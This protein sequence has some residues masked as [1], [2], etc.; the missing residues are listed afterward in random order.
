M[1]SVKSRINSL[2]SQAWHALERVVEQLEREWE[3][4]RRPTIDDLL[5]AE[6]TLRSALVIELAHAELECRLRA[7][8]PARAEDYLHKYPELGDD[9]AAALELIHTEYRIRSEHDPGLPVEEYLARFPHYS[10]EL[11]SRLREQAEPVPTTSPG[12]QTALDPERT[13]SYTPGP[14]AP[15]PSD[16]PRVCLRRP[17]D[18]TDLPLQDFTAALPAQ[19]G[20]CTILGVLARGGMG[21]VLK[22]HDAEL[23]RDLA[24][25]V[26]LD[27]FQDQPDL[28]RRFL[29][30]AQ[31]SG[32][33]QHPGIVPVY[34][35]GRLLDHR[36]YFT[37]KLVGGRTLAALL[38]ARAA[39]RHTANVPAGAEG[40]SAPQELPRFLK[41]FEQVCQTLAYAHARGVIHR[42]LKPAN[43]MVGAFGEVQVMDWGLAKVLV[44]PAS[45]VC[46]PTE[47]FPDHPTADL[48]SRAGS[49]AG[50]PA[51]MA[52][53]QAR[54][55]TERLDERCDVFGLGAI[56]CEMLTG[57]PPYVSRSA[58]DVMRQAEQGDLTHAFSRL[59][60]CAADGELLRLARSCLAV[61]VEDRPRDAGVVAG[62]MTAYLAGVQERL[63]AAEVAR[64]AAQAKAEEAK[65]KAAAERRAK[66][67][68][69]ALLVLA[70][71]AAGGLGTAAQLLYAAN[72]R[73]SEA[74]AKAEDH[75]QL[76]RQAR[77]KAED[78]LQ[79]ARS[80][81]NTYFTKV[82]DS[83]ELKAHGLEKL[84]FELLSAAKDFSERFAQEQAGDA[85]IEEE[86]AAAH[87]RLGLIA[88]E[89]GA[90]DQ[91]LEHRQQAVALFD[92]LAQAHPDDL[93]IQHNRATALLN[94]G[95]AYLETHQTKQA[96]AALE[97]SL[98]VR[99]QL[100]A[101]RPDDLLFLEALAQVNVNLGFLF[102]RTGE[103]ERARTGFQLA[104]T[105][106]EP[107]A[108]KYPQEPRLRYQ[109]AGSSY[110]LGQLQREAK[111]LSA[112]EADFERARVILTDLTLE[113][114]DPSYRRRLADTLSELAAIYTTQRKSKEANRFLALAL[115]L[116]ELLTMQ[117]PDVPEYKAALASNLNDLG[118]LY[119]TAAQAEKALQAYQRAFALFEELAQQE[120]TI[121]Y[122]REKMATVIGNV[123]RMNLRVGHAAKAQRACEQ[124][125]SISEKLANE[126]PL[127]V[128][129]QQLLGHALSNQAEFYAQTAQRILAQRTYE[130]AL[131]LY[132][133]L[134]KSHPE[135]PTYQ[136]GRARNLNDLAVL[137]RQAG[138]PGLAQERF[139]QAEEIL[140][141]LVK[142]DTG[143][144]EFQI[145]LARIER[146]LGDL[147]GGGKRL[148]QAQKYF[149]EGAA[150]LR[151]QLRQ[152]SVSPE[153]QDMFADI[154]AKLG[155]L[156]QSGKRF[157]Q[158]EPCFAEAVPVL[159]KLV[160]H[161][162]QIAELRHRLTWTQLSLAGSRAGQGAHAEATRTAEKYLADTAL[163]PTN[164]YTAACIYALAA[165][166]PRDPKLAE[167]YAARAVALLRQAIG[168]G[169]RNFANLRSDADLESLRG[170][171]DFA[172]L[173]KGLPD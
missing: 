50:T 80:T 130:R 134:A 93:S 91:A 64:A 171:A 165:A 101:T 133:R 90:M 8:E 155:D 36:P 20:R 43:I 119:A 32:Q 169:Y 118:N 128:S 92:A 16:V 21:A 131:A 151:E 55:E 141:K 72:E 24:V 47:S 107:L 88:A 74:R 156:H 158:A 132:E 15:A 94:L 125:V 170:R 84:R 95:L 34:E 150:I 148:A 137:A 145:D 7:G 136:L 159:E 75:L 123:G 63:R 58:G 41:I 147:H 78:H 33:L 149:E 82:S 31:V 67:L 30:E 142:Q 103:R 56:L 14:Q 76:A 97:Q 83:Q 10:S 1:A 48:E 113:Y 77:A 49:V 127:V 65:A 79:L 71:L 164:I 86:R 157:A 114:R 105:T 37:M 168:K 5:P 115:P 53:E 54:G 161:H 162:P 166:S 18:E 40:G 44:D 19:A 26:L 13:C 110:N 81:V 57:Q 73:E 144:T 152:G 4:G 173:L 87:G 167:Q 60:A 59:D 35:L 112:A 3:Q 11:R 52:P 28:V 12:S 117:H 62:A 61:Q 23:G 96:Q 9:G 104:R 116:N 163:A 68:T 99:Q 25:K 138:R 69:R 27:K 85:R 146:N 102:R 6:S 89:T 139:Q 111:E 39:A 106:L 17:P 120:P 135:V 46:Q 160:E 140:R 45:R 126:L 70:V 108:K 51:Y 100:L 2:D 22:G 172:E 153:L 42:D 129:Y 66:R 122:H 121:P 124:A 29:V 98:D 109:L 143:V 154:L 38:A